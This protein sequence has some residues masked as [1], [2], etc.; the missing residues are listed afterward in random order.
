MCA[1]ALSRWPR[2]KLDALWDMLNY[3]T[4]TECNDLND[5]GFCACNTLSASHPTHPISAKLTFTGRRASPAE[6]TIPQTQN[7][8]FINEYLN[9]DIGPKDRIAASQSRSAIYSHVQRFRR[10]QNLRTLPGSREAPQLKSFFPIS[11]TRSPQS[12]TQRVVH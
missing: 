2:T 5:Y 12:P 3:C 7:H 9:S 8:L 11:V 1:L 4:G 10:R 6:S